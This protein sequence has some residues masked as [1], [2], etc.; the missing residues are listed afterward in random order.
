M[1]SPRWEMNEIE[2]SFE[3]ETERVMISLSGS[4]YDFS[5]KSLF[6]LRPDTEPS[7]PLRLKICA[8]CLLSTTAGQLAAA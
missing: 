1:V 5:Y 2:N 4:S 6:S 7:P 8:H 3:H